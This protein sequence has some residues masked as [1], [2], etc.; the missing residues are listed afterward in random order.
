MAHSKVACEG[1][2]PA[3]GLLLCTQVTAHLLL[4]RVVDGILMAR[5]VVRSREDGVAGLARRGVDALALVGPVLG[6]AKR[7]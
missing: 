2:V 1:I 4:A 6:V 3:E 5:E 7:R